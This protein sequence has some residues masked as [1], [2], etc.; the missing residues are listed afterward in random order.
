[1]NEM[2]TLSFDYTQIDSA[3]AAEARATAERIQ[4][5]I[6]TSYFDTG[7]D[8]IAMKAKM[9]HGV[10]GAWI[11]AEFSLTDRT[12]ENYMNAA[13]LLEGK[14]EMVSILPP[15]VVYALAAPSASPEVVDGVIEAARA[16]KVLSARDIK[17]RLAE[18]AEADRRARIKAAITPEQAKKEREARK[19]RESAEAAR[20]KRIDEEQ[21]ARES[22]SS[23]KAEKVARFLVSKIGASG[24]VDLIDMMHGTDWHRVAKCFRPKGYSQTISAAGIAAQYGVAAGEGAASDGT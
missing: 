4:N 3:L 13:R 2:Q 22:V 7:R 12:A 18:A 5:R 17:A 10:F 6:R 19:R 24:V 14:S 16:G 23:A 15:A 21:A 20:L 11:K 8:L 9:P 1:M